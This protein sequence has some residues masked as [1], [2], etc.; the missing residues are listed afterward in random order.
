MNNPFTFKRMTAQK[1]KKG[2][3]NQSDFLCTNLHDMLIVWI[4]IE[5]Y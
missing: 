5:R 4:A 1:L 2:V 3:G